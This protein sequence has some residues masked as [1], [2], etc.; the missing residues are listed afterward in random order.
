[1][2]S[3]NRLVLAL[4]AATIVVACGAGGS[5][6]VT[7][8]PSSAYNWKDFKVNAAGNTDDGGSTCASYGGTCH[9]NLNSTKKCTFTINISEL[10]PA[11]Y[12][13]V[14]PDPMSSPFSVNL[15]SCGSTES[16]T[17]SINN[18]VVQFSAAKSDQGSAADKAYVQL[19]GVN[20]TQTIF[21]VELSADGS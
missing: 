21:N 19:N 2:K 1:M 8:P 18:C 4:A 15:T 13:Q 6:K 5:S 12:I 3:V 16:A 9:C 17:S 10:S 11:A 20:G 7:P 14:S